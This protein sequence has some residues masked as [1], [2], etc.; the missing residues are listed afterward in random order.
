MTTFY[1]GVLFVSGFASYMEFEGVNHI[2]PQWDVMSE[3]VTSKVLKAMDT[4]TSHYTHP[5]SVPVTNTRQIQ[6]M[7]DAISYQKGPYYFRFLQE[8][9]THFVN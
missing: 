7:F 8:T 3:I 5:I 9:R 4:D 6:E 2:R 1:F